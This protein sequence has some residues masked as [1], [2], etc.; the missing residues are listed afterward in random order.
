M[1]VL[2]VAALL[3]AVSDDPASGFR[4]VERHSTYD[5]PAS[6]LEELRKKMR[7]LQLH[8]PN[9]DPSSGM[10]TQHMD[11]T[12]DIERVADVCR[13]YDLRVSVEVEIVLPRLVP[14]YRPTSEMLQH[15][16]AMLAG[17]TAHE[18]GHR[19]NIEHAGRE[20]YDRLEAIPPNADCKKLRREAER[21]QDAVTLR[22]QIRDQTYDQRT[23]H[24]VLQGSHL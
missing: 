24:G 17:L 6:T 5:V 3:L 9:D 11:L 7:E 16:D 18:E 8:G 10:T 14:H 22:L 19:A 4:Y 23:Q 1:S 15:W 2:I 20:L 13:I 21:I 12:Y